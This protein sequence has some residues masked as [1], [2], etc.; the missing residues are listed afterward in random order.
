MEEK[1][2]L[3]YDYELMK[4]AGALLNS[5]TVKGVENI[6][7]LAD[8]LDSGHFVEEND[9]AIIKHKKGGPDD[10]PRKKEGES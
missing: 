8:I 10:G 1:R 4:R 7:A 5:I 9:E 2:T 3:E 6:R